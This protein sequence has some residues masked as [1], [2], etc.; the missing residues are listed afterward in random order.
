MITDDRPLLDSGTY[1]EERQ[2]HRKQNRPHNRRHKKDHE[3]L[4]EGGNVFELLINTFM[5]VLLDLKQHVCNRPRRLT[6]VNE[7]GNFERKI[8][9]VFEFLSLDIFK[10]HH[11]AHLFSHHHPFAYAGKLAL[12]MQA[13]NGL[14][15][16]F[17]GFANE[18]TAP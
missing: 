10:P 15:G 4:D 2:H 3:R 16:N 13:G 9:I 6:D 11:F 18:H 1:I 17:K 14:F 7:L 5:I 12:I 8:T